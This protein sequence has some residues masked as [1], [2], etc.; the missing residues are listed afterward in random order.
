[1][2][3]EDDFSGPEFSLRDDERPQR[4]IGHDAARI[5]DDMR[6]AFTEAENPKD[7]QARIHTR[8][9]GQRFRR[10]YRERALALIVNVGTHGPDHTIVPMRYPANFG[11]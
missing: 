7:I 1:M 11:A 6:F 8:N 9:D 3:D 5:A 2:V 10:P 4:V